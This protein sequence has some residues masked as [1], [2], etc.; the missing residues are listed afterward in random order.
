MPGEGSPYGQLNL[1]RTEAVCLKTR[2]PQ[3]LRV[4]RQ[5]AGVGRQ[6][7]IAGEDYPGCDIERR[8]NTATDRRKS[9]CQNRIYTAFPRQPRETVLDPNLTLGQRGS[10][11][12]ADRQELRS[13]VASVVS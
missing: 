3:I 11:Q 1:L 10:V 8:E 2:A 6:T 13:V 5:V 7:A 4:S 9:H 12:T